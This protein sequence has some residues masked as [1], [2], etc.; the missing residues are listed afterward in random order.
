MHHSD[1]LHMVQNKMAIGISFMLS[2][3][4]CMIY[5]VADQLSGRRNLPVLVLG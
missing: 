3:G 1:Q 4:L 5:L 2:I